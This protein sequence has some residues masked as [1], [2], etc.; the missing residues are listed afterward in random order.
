MKLLLFHFFR[1][2]MLTF[3]VV[4]VAVFSDWPAYRS[5]PEAT[6]LLTLSFS[7]GADRKAACRRRTAD[8]LAALPPNMRRAEVCPRQRPTVYVELDVD[9]AR[10]YSA[11]LPPTGIAGDGPSRVYERF[12]LPAGSYDVAVRLREN[13]GAST[14]F[15]YTAERTIELQPADHRVIDFRPEAGGFVFH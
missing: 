11:Q 13:P 9:G 15:D 4:G 1:L 5:L 6:G 10:L 8:E 2:V 7:H 14:E 12:P 3:A